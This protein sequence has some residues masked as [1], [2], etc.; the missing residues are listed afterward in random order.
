MI[1]YEDNYI[2]DSGPVEATEAPAAAETSSQPDYE[3]Q[4]RQQGWKPKEEFD[5]PVDRWRPAE[6]FVKRGNDTPAILRQRVDKLDKALNSVREQARADLESERKAMADRFDRQNRMAE[7][8]LQRQRETYENQIATAKREAVALGDSERYEQLERHEGFVKKQ[9]AD[10]DKQIAPK[11]D[12]PVAAAAPAPAPEV[13]SWMSKNPWFNKDSA[14]TEVATAYEDYLARAKPGLSLDER[15]EL[16]RKHVVSEFPHKFGKKAAMN[17]ADT[18]RGSSPVE[19]STRSASGASDND[20]GFSGLPAEA[21]QQFKSF[22]K[23]KLFTDDAAGRRKYATY[24]NEPN[25]DKI[26]KA[27]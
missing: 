12:T 22:V 2:E 13:A 3:S 26:K 14:L 9:W 23:E 10:D 15:L 24:Y 20:G 7:L 18:G 21:R 1:D 27:D 4:A 17:G 11:A 5:G 8:A 16:T 19:G 25:S 6:E